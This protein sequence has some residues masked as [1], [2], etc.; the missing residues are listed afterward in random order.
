MNRSHAFVATLGLLAIAG[1]TTLAGIDDIAYGE[2]ATNASPTDPSDPSKRGGD[3]AAPGTTTDGAPVVPQ[4]GD[5]DAGPIDDDDDAGNVV[6]DAGNDAP[7]GVDVIV[8]PIDAGNVDPGGDTEGP[9]L[10]RCSANEYQTGDRQAPGASRVIT[11][12]FPSLKYAPRCMRIKVG[13]SVTWTYDLA[14]NPL[15]PLTQNPPSPIVLTGAGTSVTF[16]FTQVGRY[17]FGST[18]GSTLRGTI[19]VRP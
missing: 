14:S 13:Q 9:V 6:I 5:P 4:P 2:P 17:R 3:D 19:D 16:T 10:F 11:L 7:V 8:P 18:S 12:P 1:C 15:E